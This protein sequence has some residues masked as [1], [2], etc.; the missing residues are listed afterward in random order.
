MDLVQA[1][2]RFNE[3][4]EKTGI[5]SRLGQKVEP[6]HNERDE[7]WGICRIFAERIY[8]LDIDNNASQD[9]I[10]ELC[11]FTI[12]ALHWNDILMQDERFSYDNGRF[13]RDTIAL[14]VCLFTRISRNYSEYDTLKNGWIKPHINFSLLMW[15][16][17]SIIDCNADNIFH[18]FDKNTAQEAMDLFLDLIAES[19]EK[20]II[21]YVSMR[22]VPD[23]HS[24][25][26]IWWEIYW[27][28]NSSRIPYQFVLNYIW[29]H[30]LVFGA[31]ALG[32]HDREMNKSYLK[33]QVEHKQ[34]PPDWSF[35]NDLAFIYIF[36]ATETD[37]TLAESEIG[38][39]KVKLAEWISGDNEDEKRTELDQAFDSSKSQFDT[40]ASKERF[41]FVLENIRRHFFKKK[42][43]NRDKIGGQLSFVLEDLVAIAKA[44]EVIIQEEYDLVEEIRL[45]WGIDIKLFDEDIV[46]KFNS[47]PT[48]PVEEPKEKETQ[49]SAEYLE[50]YP[51]ELY[52]ENE[53]WWR[54]GRPLHISNFP[55]V[56]DETNYQYRD[57]F[58]RFTQEEVDMIVNKIKSTGSLIYLNFVWETMSEK[59]DLRGMKTPFWFIPFGIYGND[60]AGVFYF[61]QNGIYN[62][63]NDPYGLSM[64]IH[65]DLWNN[66]SFEQGYN[67][68]T[69]GWGY[70]VDD[71]DLL[72]SLR[73]DY[74]H[75][76]NFGCI[77]V[78]E[79]HNKD[80]ASTLPVVQAIW[81]N[82]WQGVVDSSKNA[83]C[84]LLG[85]PPFTEYFESW[86]ELLNWAGSDDDDSSAGEPDSQNE[87]NSKE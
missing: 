43:G 45:L 36:F 13:R 48:D 4:A 7:L 67:G 62:N 12:V 75:K 77:N 71:K 44:D 79:T 50:N 3:I 61:E 65:C 55:N 78:V 8:K 5:L 6:N 83:G 17:R 34:F 73:I 37:G 16:L 11:H 9:E 51:G 86:E 19:T 59:F 27:R 52:C 38:Q 15:T 47:V 40:D 85:P 35:H 69:D 54:S 23:G 64:V 81:D 39:I 74:K 60:H 42:E 70:D 72:S 18:L 49:S 24:L 29:G 68:L 26:A 30:P 41:S 14:A 56:F 25:R 80:Y 63:C 33:R 58:R 31:V 82:A 21:G 2:N 46:A 84:Y 1:K 20:G 22:D 32:P 10:N 66:I 28:F 87:T 76:G 57:L 53:H